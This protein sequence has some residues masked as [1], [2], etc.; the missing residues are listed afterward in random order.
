VLSHGLESKYL[1]AT[2]QPLRD[3]AILILETGVRPGEAANLQWTDVY[4]QPAI[5]A[6]FGYIAIR[7]GKSRNAKRNL[8]L[9]ARVAEMLNAR[10]AKTESD[11]VFPGDSSDAPILVTSFDHQHKEVR[12][13]LKL[14]GEFVVHSLRHRDV[15]GIR[16]SSGE[17]G[18]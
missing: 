1:E 7:S 17:Q 13:T 18:F 2:R 12:D 15:G 3:V 10:K 14:S 16:M 5:R 4:L 6:K 11:W 9:T 8:S